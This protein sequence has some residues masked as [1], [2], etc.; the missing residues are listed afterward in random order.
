[1]TDK[2]ESLQNPRIKQVRALRLAKNRKKFGR[3]VIEGEKLVQEALRDC[4]AA[5]VEIYSVAEQSERSGIPIQQVSPQVFARM[6]GMQE[7]PGILAVI[8]TRKIP[9][10]DSPRKLLL[11]GI[12][13]PGNVGT[14]LRTA[15]AFD[16]SVLLTKDSVDPLNPKAVQASMGSLLRHMPRWV[17]PKEIMDLR[18]SHQFYG[19]S[20]AGTETFPMPNR[21]IVLILGS[22]SHGMR[23]ELAAL[24]HHK[25]RIPMEGETE[26]LN[27]AVAG[28]IFMHRFYTNMK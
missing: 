2:I 18:A 3:F 14:L 15:E 5:I 24:V 7:P 19:T 13:D 26:S 20:P 9:H 27:V 4:P 1:M 11:D 25:L 8:E 12:S 16:F 23:K 6:S 28:G 21:P 17:S 10:R 22:E